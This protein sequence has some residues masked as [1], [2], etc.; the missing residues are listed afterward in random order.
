MVLVTDWY[1]LQDSSPSV[2][3]VRQ[4]TKQD[5]VKT[6]Q[7]VGLLKIIIQRLNGLIR[8]YELEKQA[9]PSKYHMMHT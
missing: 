7:C 1:V 6:V 4:G 3:K 8:N 2:N 9:N 5:V